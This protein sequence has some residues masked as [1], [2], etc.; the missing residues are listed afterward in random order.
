MTDYSRISSKLGH[1][2]WLCSI[3]HDDGQ[4]ASDGGGKSTTYLSSPGKG[5][6]TLMAQSAQLSKY[7]HGGKMDFINPFV[8]G[9]DVS[10][11]KIFLETVIWR[12]RDFDALGNIIPENWANSFK[13]WTSPIKKLHLWVH[14][15][16]DVVFYALNHKKQPIPVKNLPPIEYYKSADELMS[17]LHWGAINAILEPQTY[18]LSHMLIQKLREKRMDV[19]E[20][21]EDDE[22][23][24][25]LNRKRKEERKKPFAKRERIPKKKRGGRGTASDYEN[26]EVSPAYFWFDMIHTAM[27]A[28]KTKHIQFCI[29]EWDDIAEARSEGDVW[30]L[31]DVL[32]SDWKT[33]RKSNIS[34]HLSTHQTDYIDWRILKRIDYFIWMKGAIIHPTYSM[35]NSQNII[36]DL[37]VG[38]FIIEEKKVSFGIEDFNKIP[39]SQPTLR[40]DGLKGQTLRLT[41]DQANVIMRTMA[42]A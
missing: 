42:E 33:L 39:Y 17:R 22:T 19:N 35:I 9:E 12:I 7:V 37:P 8:A 32:A 36:S 27:E 21:T 16:D 29:D 14:E 18:K 34:T 4:F 25:D 23:R 10:D 30:K 11:F 13:N 6:S 1:K 28:N 26:R 15:D 31:I 3:I 41:A 20:D 2:H 5:K 24:E 38:K 40:I